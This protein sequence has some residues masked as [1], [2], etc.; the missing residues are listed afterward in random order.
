[1]AE[2]AI[3]WTDRNYAE[4]ARR[5]AKR[6]NLETGQREVVLDD[7]GRPAFER[8]PQTGRVGVVRQVDDIAQTKPMSLPRFVNMLRDDG[9]EAPIIIRTAA[10][11][12]HGEQG[13]DNTFQ[14]Y[15]GAKAKR[16]GWIP[17]GACPVAMAE[18]GDINPLQLDSRP[19]RQAVANREGCK[20]HEVGVNKPPCKHYQAEKAART[21]H[22]LGEHLASVEREK[23]SA[24]RTTDALVEFVNKMDARTAPAPATLP[25]MEFAPRGPKAGK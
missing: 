17:E 11:A 7:R 13:S 10:A 23:T 4:K 5:P 18:R 8:V 2:R 6:W 14:R 24:D 20:P 21:A 9:N 15:Q 22:R 25:E 16:H 19:L 3:M 12:G 1:M